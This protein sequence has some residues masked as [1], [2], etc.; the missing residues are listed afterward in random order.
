MCRHPGT[1][2]KPVFGTHQSDENNTIDVSARPTAGLSV[3][4]QH[5]LISV[6]GHT[7][8]DSVF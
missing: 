2:D 8:T 5:V 6:H 7:P 3:H 1:L 4:V